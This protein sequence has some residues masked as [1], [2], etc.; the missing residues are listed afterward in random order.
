MATTQSPSPNFADGA[1]V[2]YR[3]LGE[4]LIERRLIEQEDLGEI[5]AEA[6]PCLVLGAGNRTPRA[7]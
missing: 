4:I 6:R 3:R 2:R 7:S 1:P 5:V